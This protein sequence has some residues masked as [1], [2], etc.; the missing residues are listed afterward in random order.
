[1]YQRHSDRKGR[2][3]LLCT[4]PSLTLRM[5]ISIIIGR[6]MY[7]FFRRLVEIDGVAVVEVK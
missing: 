7:A 1:M 5:T 6:F 2:I 3:S 4:D